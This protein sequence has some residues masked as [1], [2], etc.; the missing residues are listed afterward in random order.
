V[1][2]AMAELV[3][4]VGLRGE[5]RARALED[6]LEA[7]LSTPFV[8]R[9]RPGQ[10]P[11]A[12]ELDG[13]RWQGQTLVVKLRGVDDRAAA[14]QSVSDRLG[15]LGEDYDRDG[16]PRPEQHP[17]FVFRGLQVRTVEGQ[18]AGTV[19]DVLTMPSSLVLR[20]VRP[21]A[22]DALVP[23]VPELVPQVDRGRGVVVV[24]AIP[25]LL[26]GEAWIDEET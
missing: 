15:F 17:P 11:V 20:I 22:A 21:G 18:P 5:L 9:Q 10:V 16:F 24:R 25:G 26:D 12:A 3:R 13:Y 8:R 23:V 19:A 1:F 4:P 7:V 14:E 2:V 6:F